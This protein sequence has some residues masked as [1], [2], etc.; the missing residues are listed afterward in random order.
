M[1]YCQKCEFCNLSLNWI[2]IK[3]KVFRLILG[4]IQP[5]D[6]KF[7]NN[8]NHTDLFL[9][10]KFHNFRLNR[11][12]AVNFSFFFDRQ[13]LANC[14][15]HWK[16]DFE[17][18]HKLGFIC[19]LKYSDVQRFKG[20]SFHKFNFVVFCIVVLIKKVKIKIN[21]VVVKIAIYSIKF[22]GNWKIY[23]YITII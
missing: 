14:D 8:I 22:W 15:C 19:I 18:K 16:Q 3:I 10:P 11:M 13:N 6:L 17:K 12:R 7:T 2:F 9:N 23:T 4:S 21:S 5:I 20:W 1:K